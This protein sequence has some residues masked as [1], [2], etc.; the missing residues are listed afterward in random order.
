VVTVLLGLAHSTE[1]GFDAKALALHRNMGIAVALLAAVLFLLRTL[2]STLYQRTQLLTGPLAIVLVAL[3]GHYGGDMTH[4]SSYLFAHAPAGLQRLAGVQVARRENVTVG[5]ADV[6]ADLIQPM[7]MKRCSN[8]HGES[9]RKGGLSLVSHAELMKGGKQ[10]TAVVPGDLTQSELYYRI[11]LPPGSEDFMPAENK[12]PLT[13]EQVEI[14][15][16]WIT[17]GAPATGGV[18]ALDP[19]PPVLKSI[20]QQ[21]QDRS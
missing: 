10:F 5:T 3:T 4:G 8:C 6:F 16:W 15:G 1:G 12:T 21:F 18:L 19:P 14:I 13:A 11:T 2:R 17:A 9:T 20:E 7:L